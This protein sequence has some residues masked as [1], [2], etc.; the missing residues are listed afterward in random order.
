V[1]V[2]FDVFSFSFSEGNTYS[3]RF[4]ETVAVQ[5][6]T[7]VTGPFSFLEGESSLQQAL[8][9]PIAPV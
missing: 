8:E 1:F 6:R 7:Q 3:F 5:G 9:V 4:D 2:V